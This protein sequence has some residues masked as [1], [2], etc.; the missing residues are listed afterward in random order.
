MHHNRAKKGI[1]VAIALALVTV[2][3]GAFYLLYYV[4]DFS[5][6][7]GEPVIAV[8]SSE[9]QATE[10]VPTL[11]T[12]IPANKNAI[13]CASFLAAWKTLE[14]DLAKEPVTLQGDP[15]IAQTL[16]KAVD[17]RPYIPNE[18]LYVAA[19]WNQE[20][21]NR[22]DQKRSRGKVSR[23]STAHLPR[24]GTKFVPCLC[25]SCGKRE[26]HYPVLPEPQAVGVYR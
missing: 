6:P 2:A 15:A 14:T 1:I 10:V 24:N 25:I 21:Y 26:V 19:G 17:P 8:D 3:A 22:P 11:D 9:L 4:S 23:Q 16:N 7:D 12:P 20:G 5:A 18:S 13:W